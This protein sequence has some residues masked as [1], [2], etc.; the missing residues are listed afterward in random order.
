MSVCDYAAS[1]ASN[2]TI[3]PELYED[4]EGLGVLIGFLGAA[5]LVIA[6]IVVHYLVFFDPELDP[7]D[8]AAACRGYAEGRETSFKPN[9][10]DVMLLG[11]IR[12]CFGNLLHWIG[13]SRKSGP[14]SGL[15]RL[16]Q[17]MTSCILNFV[18]LQ[19][20]AGLG[21]LTSGFI[22]LNDDL[23]A[24][25]W[26][27][28]VYLAWLSSVTH[29]SGLTA[30]RDYF[31][32]R[33][34]ERG[35]RLALMF[36]FIVILLVALVPTAF[37]NWIAVNDEITITQ[38]ASP[39]RCYF[40]LDESLKAYREQNVPEDE[41]DDNLVPF[42][43][44]QA[45]QSMIVG[46]IL[47]VLNFFSR[48]LRVFRP[49]SKALD[50]GVRKRAGNLVKRALR[51]L[52]KGQ[53]LFSWVLN[54]RQWDLMMVK[55][56]L[57]LF[58]VWRFYIDL[59]LSMPSEVYWLSISSLWATLHLF[60]LRSKA[61]EKREPPPADEVSIT[62]TFGQTLPVVMLLAP[63]ITA[64]GAFFAH[65]DHKKPT[66]DLPV[67]AGMNGGVEPNNQA[68]N[69]I[70][71]ASSR[72]AFAGSQPEERLAYGVGSM[73]P[74]LLPGPGNSPAQAIMEVETGADTQDLAW[75]QRNYYDTNWAPAICFWSFLQV[76]A[77][78][79]FLIIPEIPNTE[80]LSWTP[81]QLIS[82]LWAWVFL[83]QP[84]AVFATALINIAGEEF[85]R[86]RRWLRH[87]LI[88]HGLILIFWV[89]SAVSFMVSLFG[90]GGVVK[91]I[92]LVVFLLL[93]SLYFL[94][95]LVYEVLVFF[96]A[97]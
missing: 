13:L 83:G 75:L 49:V 79:V 48:A 97:R 65:S 35:W 34:W 94:F 5:W 43:G 60:Y 76:A 58:L 39:A 30:L 37:F 6:M 9:P 84:A 46:M 51:K 88:C 12:R 31:H 66:T 32:N 86:S 10:V 2:A 29:L 62:W 89:L 77:V 17:S 52:P 15:S 19:L 95:M 26:F 47:L 57:A 33:K 96:M 18:D 23:S 41:Y 68:S 11:S 93:L 36:V 69:D 16:R 67:P 92:T 85:R 38:P 82:G 21:V 50:R 55:P 1:E 14:S 78:G 54:E 4:I 80:D 25:H 53:R 45:F 72:Q 8:D 73:R 24:H 22:S 61:S 90:G 87:P 74:Y 71:P 42:S 27:I 28:I 59:L 3:Y 7:F 81:L 20:I 56:C 70:T 64:A 91:W 40:S 63:A 44:T